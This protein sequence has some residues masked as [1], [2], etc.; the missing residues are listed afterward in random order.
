M[1]CEG[2]KMD[3][4]GLLDDLVGQWFGHFLRRNDL[5]L[6]LS[7]YDAGNP[8][9]RHPDHI[10]KMGN[11]S[12]YFIKDSYLALINERKPINSIIFLG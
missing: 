11:F 6:V 12:V 9:F 2:W 10:S 3:H 1:A 8:F 5:S 4:L 7:K